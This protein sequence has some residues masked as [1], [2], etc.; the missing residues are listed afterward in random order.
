LAV[1]LS[2]TNGVSAFPS[3]VGVDVLTGGAALAA[4]AI[5]AAASSAISS[6]AHRVL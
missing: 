1:S 6:T 5:V 3:I 2:P 4:V